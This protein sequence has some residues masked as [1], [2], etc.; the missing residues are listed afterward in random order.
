HK[1]S[2]M[3]AGLFQHTISM[4]ASPLCTYWA[5]Q[6][7][8][9]AEE[10]AY[11]LGSKFGVK[12]R[13]ADALVKKLLEVP[14]EEIIQKSSE[15]PMIPFRPTLERADVAPEEPKF[16]TVCPPKKYYDG[17]YNKG[18]HMMGYTSAEIL[19]MSSTLDDLIKWHKGAAQSIKRYKIAKIFPTTS[20]ILAIK[21]EAIATLKRKA[22][23]NLIKRLSDVYFVSGIDMTQQLLAKTNEAPVYYYRYDFK[24]PES[25]HKS[26]GITILD[27]VAHEDELPYIFHRPH[28]KMSFRDPEIARNRDRLVRMWTNFARY[29]DPTPFGAEDGRLDGV[30]WP[31]SG[32]DGAHLEINGNL[33]IVKTRRTNPLIT[34][35][36]KLNFGD[37][38][39]YKNCNQSVV[40][41]IISGVMNIPVAVVEI[42]SHFKKY[43]G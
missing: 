19:S 25:A 1:L 10:Q 38:N 12:S 39:I 8:E 20:E 2:N 11:S 30:T 23:S 31:D 9:E 15:L 28:L 6:S 5:F 41:D 35:Y 4:S 34:L 32:K 42:I 36:Q 43:F 7:Y 21:F 3:S 17:N 13:D 14:A 24:S 37:S 27:G 29:G 40:S 33:T 26:E 16:I 18:P 22:F